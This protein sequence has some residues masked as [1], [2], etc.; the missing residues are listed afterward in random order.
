MQS[1]LSLTAVIA[2]TAY[3]LYFIARRAGN[4]PPPPLCAAVL[5]TACVELFDLATLL[6][7]ALFPVW[8]RC[9]LVAEALL[10]FTWL[11]FSLT[12]ARRHEPHAIPLFQRLLLILSPLFA[13][14]A[15]FVP[16]GAIYYSPDFAEERILFLGNAGFFFYLLLFVYLVTALTN[17]ER[18]FVAT[19]PSARWRI[20]YELLGAGGLLAALAFYYSQALLFRTLS[21]HLL[22][23]RT[24]MLLVAVVMMGYSRIVRGN[25]VKVYISRQVAYRSVVLFAVGV[26]LSALALMGE[27][28]KYFGNGF[29]RGMAITVAFV[30]GLA[31]V[32]TLLS[33]RCKR[34]IH[35]FLHRNFYQN[36]YDYRTQW[37]Q[38]T[39]RLSTSKSGDDLLRAIVAGF[40]DTFGMGCGAL[41][42][43]K[44]DGEAYRQAVEIALEPPAPEFTSRDPA[45]A[46]AAVRTG[47]IDLRGDATGPGGAEQHRFLSANAISFLVFLHDGESMDGF[48][49]LGKPVNARERFDDE[50]FDL[51][52]TLARQ[53]TAALLNLRLSEQ[54]ARSREMAAVGRVSAFV[55]HDLK[56]L[57]S[58]IS[59]MLDNAREYIASPPFQEEML[60]SL[61]TSVD[62]MKALISRLHHLPEKTTLQIAPLDLL[63]LARETAALVT[64]GEIR[65]TGTPVVAMGDR[66][67]L[68]K[69]A[70]NLMLN[71]VEATEGEEPISVEVGKGDGGY[72]RVIDRGC[73]IPE[74]FLRTRIFAPFTTTKRKGLGIGLYQSKQIVEAHGGRIEVKSELNHGSEFTV[75]LPPATPTVT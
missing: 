62:K 41:F 68:Q 63:Q 57:V 21:M 43:L 64:K 14:A 70:L 67:E 7:P 13:A 25:G 47:V 33:E 72:L 37:L 66:E 60:A 4:A 20:Q 51:M 28:M 40:C 26:Y 30:A 55:M 48:V 35:A 1:I 18:T 24:T 17:L 23:V 54:L 71:A 59:L 22:P 65:V 49:L 38:F 45:F 34:R 11:W 5:V 29:Q 15:L 6:D 44:Q 74:D 42:L 75:L 12:Y 69:V 32:T 50:D 73:G 19:T 8:K 31:L 39:D 46:E 3:P 58:A 61:A 10:P 2:A 27:G 52:R 56:N 16:A 36:K 53:A 9:A